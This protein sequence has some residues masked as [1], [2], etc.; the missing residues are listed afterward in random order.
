[1]SKL[2][3]VGQVG[4]EGA[5][6]P[7]GPVPAGRRQH[8]ASFPEILLMVGLLSLLATFVVPPVMQWFQQ[9]EVTRTMRDDCQ[10]VLL[11][12]VRKGGQGHPGHNVPNCTDAA[13]P[14]P[15]SAPASAAAAQ[16]R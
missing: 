9:S 6:M 14:T 8:G 7:R 11:D 10:V 1:M 5:A 3:Q 16:T 12:A 2:T 15:A 4:R 13:A